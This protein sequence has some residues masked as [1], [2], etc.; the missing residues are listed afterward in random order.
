LC[1]VESRTLKELSLTSEVQ[2]C[3]DKSTFHCGTNTLVFHVDSC[4][5][6]RTCIFVIREKR[7]DVNYVLQGQGSFCGLLQWYQDNEIS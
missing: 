1:L 7:I 6:S 4:N 2:E 5:S 3:T